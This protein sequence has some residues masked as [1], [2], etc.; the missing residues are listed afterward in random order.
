MRRRPEF[1]S[2]Y[3]RER[4][5]TSADDDGRHNVS[6]PRRDGVVVLSRA[7]ATTIVAAAGAER[8]FLRACRKGAFAR[9][10]VAFVDARRWTWSVASL[11]AF[12]RARTP[13][14]PRST[15][16]RRRRGGPCAGSSSSAP[17]SPSDDAGDTPAH[18]L[19]SRRVPPH[20][21][22]RAPRAGADVHRV[23][24]ARG[25][26]PSDIAARVVERQTRRLLEAE[27][28]RAARRDAA[29]AR[30]APRRVSAASPP[31]ATPTP[32]GARRSSTKQ[33]SPRRR[34]RLGCRAR[35]RLARLL[36][37]LRRR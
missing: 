21:P 11:A 35:A 26:T 24:D 17:T 28:R 5:R 23:R 22:R 27:E 3:F 19:A 15:R 18:L 37:L 29:D 10:S 31:R 8:R 13:D 36:R 14:A 7:A 20:R 32:R 33:P 30:T 25:E 4:R 2:A 16:V 34:C 6:A 12:A 9:R 1:H